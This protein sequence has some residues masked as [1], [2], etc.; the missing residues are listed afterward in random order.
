MQAPLASFQY[1]LDSFETNEWNDRIGDPLSE[2]STVM[3]SSLWKRP[4]RFAPGPSSFV[5]NF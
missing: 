2:Y 1:R 3:L 4:R 5:V